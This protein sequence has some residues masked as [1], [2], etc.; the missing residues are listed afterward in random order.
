MNDIEK[1]PSES[2]ALIKF[3]RKVET[4][5]KKI[6]TIDELRASDKFID[7]VFKVGKDMFEIPLDQHTPDTLLR[8][9]GKLVGSYPNLAQKASYARAEHDVYEQKLDETEKELVLEKLDEKYKVTEARAIVSA[10]V[11]ELREYVIQK[12]AAKNQ[13]E[14]IV[15]AID[16]LVSF[17]QSAI[18]V[19]E[20]ERFGAGRLANNG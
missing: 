5:M 19:K 16:K 14:S 3:K 20:G 9:G 13:M 4:A 15:E 11:S 7:Y 18:K 8:M 6:A 17:A 1:A 12:H 10:E 2:A